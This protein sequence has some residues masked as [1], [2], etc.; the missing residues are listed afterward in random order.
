ETDWLALRQAPTLFV[1]PDRQD[2]TDYNE[3]RKSREEDV[4]V[5]EHHQCPDHN[6]GDQENGEAIG[7]AGAALGLEISL[8]GLP[9]L[10]SVGVWQIS[11]EGRIS[12][13]Y[14]LN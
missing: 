7:K 6:P 4:V 3:A 11:F 9:P 2:G 5:G 8:D 14:E 12:S 10:E 1:E 13:W